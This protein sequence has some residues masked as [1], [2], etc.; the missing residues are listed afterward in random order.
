MN[1]LTPYISCAETATPPSFILPTKSLAS[2]LNRSASPQMTH[3]AGNPSKLKGP[4]ERRGTCRAEG[5]RYGEERKAAGRAREQ[6]PI[7]YGARE[8]CI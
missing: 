7:A 3:V 1:D 5:E 2:S 4:V 6:R 8:S